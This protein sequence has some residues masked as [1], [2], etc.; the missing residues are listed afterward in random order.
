M[1]Q[2]YEIERKNLLT[3]T[4]YEALLDFLNHSHIE[5][6]IQVNHYFETKNFDLKKRG[7]ALRIREKNNQYTLTLKQPHKDGLLETHDSL[8]HAECKQWLKQQPVIKTNIANQLEQ[9]SIPIEGLFYGGMLQTNRIEVSYLGGL[10]ALDHSI[11][12]NKED[13]ELEVEAPTV[14]LAESIM[15]DLLTKLSITRKD[16]PNKIVR[17]YQTLP[18]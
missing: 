14:K 16:T 2:E 10:L 17:F 15:H 3:K 8:T 13:Y 18:S 1:H 11:Y 12:N 9:L 5:P 7:A 6:I 4:E